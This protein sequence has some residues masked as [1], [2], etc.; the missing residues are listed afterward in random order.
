MRALPSM[1]VL[2]LR[3]KVAAKLKQPAD[4]I[5]LWTAFAHKDVDGFWE[6]GEAMDAAREVGWYLSEGDATVLVSVG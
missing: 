1:S 2:L 5:E 3:K 6:R 4:G